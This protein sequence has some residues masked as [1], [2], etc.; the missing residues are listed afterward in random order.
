MAQPNQPANLPS[1]NSTEMLNMYIRGEHDKLS[2]QFISIFNYFHNTTYYSLSAYEQFFINCF[3]KN[4]LF[5]F[6]QPDFRIA[7]AHI[8]PYIRLNRVISNM[9]Y[10]SSTK[11]TDGVLEIL[12]DQQANYVKILTLLSARNSIRFDRK[13]LFDTNPELASLWYLIYSYIFYPGLL[14]KTSYENLREHFKFK[15][16]RLRI[17]S[18]IQEVYFGSTYAGPDMDRDIKGVVNLSMREIAARIPPLRNNPKPNKI[19]VFSA[20][21]FATHSVYRNYYAYLKALKE[22]FHLTFFQLGRY[23]QQ[24]VS[25]FDEVNVVDIVD[26]LPDLSKLRDNDFQIAYWPDIGMSPHSIFLANLRIAPIQICSPGHS[27]STFGADI[28]YFITGAD[29]E[30]PVN[31]QQ[32][33]SERLVLLPGMGVIH[34]RPLYEIQGLKKTTNDFI[35]NCPWTCQKVN[36]PFLETLKK[37]IARSPRKFKLRLFIGA[38]SYRQN[39]HLPFARDLIATLG[40]EN[41]ELY[42]S[43]DYKAYMT[44]MEVGDLSIDSFHF[45]GCNTISDSLFVRVPTVTW[46]GTKW[47]NRIGSEMLRLVGVPEC[48]ATNEDEYLSICLKLINDDEYR[49]SIRAKIQKADLDRTIYNTDDAPYFL[50]AV[51]QILAN[52]EKWKQDPL[53]TRQAIRIE[54]KRPPVVEAPSAAHSKPVPTEA[55]KKPKKK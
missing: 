40:Q 6:T 49:A 33:Y 27:V 13:I 55:A 24:E 18:E 38:S 45:G 47:Y 43:L 52:H 32:H 25:L 29:V 34:N 23:N 4:F 16:P 21:W 14:T 9:V 20:C 50:T 2:E 42:H 36:Y 5:I 12:R 46:E 30:E 39:D 1:F 44:H 19:A 26:G 17:F 10:L 54:R 31:P 37:L 15:H 11:T 8:M 48:I 22:K 53:E 28:D 3:I 7:D 35:I 41:V 51:E